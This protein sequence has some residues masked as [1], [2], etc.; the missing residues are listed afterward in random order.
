MATK[1]VTTTDQGEL[2][3][4]PPDEFSTY[5]RERWI[6]DI[7]S[8]AGTISETVLPYLENEAIKRF[9]NEWTVPKDWRPDKHADFEGWR[10]WWLKEA[11]ENCSRLHPVPKA[12]DHLS[13]AGESAVNLLVV[14]SELR[15]AISLRRADLAC[16]LGMLLVA[17]VISGGYSIEVNASKEAADVIRNARESAYRKGIG[18]KSKDLRTAQSACVE[19]ARTLW[20]KDTTM[21]IGEVA[22]SLRRM[23]LA[24]LSKLPTLT[25]ADLPGT[26]TIKNWLK[27]ADKSGNLKIPATAQRRGRPRKADK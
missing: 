6:G 11:R 10:L 21:R 4:I 12:G 22:G 3:V 16:A 5:L 24:N 15:D 1:K 25:Q 26:D 9:G 8:G 27:T 23:L 13:L 17:E 18:Q 19:A 14:A 2:L 20:E 7:E